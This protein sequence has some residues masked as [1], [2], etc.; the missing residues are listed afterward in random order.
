VVGATHSLNGKRSLNDHLPLIL[1]PCASLAFVVG[2][3]N[4]NACVFKHESHDCLTLK[5]F[6]DADL[7][8]TTQT[9]LQIHEIIIYI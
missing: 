4:L 2:S 7:S 9:I 5:F 6:H 1:P 8:L 3:V